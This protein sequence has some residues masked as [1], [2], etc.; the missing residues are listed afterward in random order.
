MPPLTLKGGASVPGQ[1]HNRDRK[2]V[3]PV[4]KLVAH[5]AVDIYI[6]YG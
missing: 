3:Q 4:G 1:E 6:Q 2:L 5:P